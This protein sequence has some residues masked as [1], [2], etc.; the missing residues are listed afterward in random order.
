MML[1]QFLEGERDLC[2]GQL[3]RDYLYFFGYCFRHVH[4]G[5]A[6]DFILFVAALT[7]Y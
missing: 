6:Q 4:R 3:A 2:F 5:P 7:I 1:F